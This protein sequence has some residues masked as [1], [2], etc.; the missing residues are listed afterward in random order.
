MPKLTFS[1][2]QYIQY[3]SVNE[4]SN[5]FL[6]LKHS[7]RTRL[8]GSSLKVSVIFSTKMTVILIR[9]NGLFLKEYFTST[10][11]FSDALHGY[12]LNFVS[13]AYSRVRRTCLKKKIKINRFK[14]LVVY[15]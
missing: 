7:Q 1:V 2:F 6:S 12:K 5:L 8:S 13:T 9:T 15:F 3:F 4:F 14:Y 11:T 10:L